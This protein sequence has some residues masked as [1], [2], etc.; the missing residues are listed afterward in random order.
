[1]SLIAQRYAAA[2][3]EVAE[4]RGQTQAVAEDLARLQAALGTAEG[5]AYLSDPRV[6]AAKLGE[7]L[8]RALQGGSEVTRNF[9]RVL[10]ERRRVAVLPDLHV[11]FMAHLRAKNGEA[12]ARVE[13]A[14]PLSEA[15][16][17]ELRDQLARLTKKRI[18]LDVHDMP[19]LIGGVRVRIGNTLYDGSLLSELEALQQRLLQSPVTRN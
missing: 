12:V 10:Q 3:F 1:M 8:G 9:V 18:V 4:S 16:Q 19:D 15:D 5:R 13:T 6:S 11:E 17:A 2:L 7:Q 14:R